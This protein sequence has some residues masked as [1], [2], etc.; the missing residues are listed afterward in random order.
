MNH[1]ET[2]WEANTWSL[3]PKPHKCLGETKQ[4]YTVDMGR[5]GERRVA[6]ESGSI[7]YLPTKADAIKRLIKYWSDKAADYAKRMAYAQAKT[8]RLYEMLAEEE[9]ADD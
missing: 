9:K 7:W 3:E 6:K 1:P 2:V 5:A 4:Q 8:D